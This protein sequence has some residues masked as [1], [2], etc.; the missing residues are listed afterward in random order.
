MVTKRGDGMFDDGAEI[1]ADK[2]E[3][4]SCRKCGRVIDVAS[5]PAFSEVS[6]PDCGTA[7]TVPAKLG[8]FLLLE[9]LGTGGMGAVYKALD[10][11]LGRYVAIKVMKRS[12]GDN[13]QFIENFMREARA[14]A[15]L[16]HPN[17]VQIYSCGQEKGQPYIVMEL[18]SGGRLDE[19]IATGNPM[20]EVRALEIGIDIAEGL[21]AAN[22]V[23]LIHG[24]V[25]PA[26]ILFD[27]K[28]V[29]KVVDFGLARFVGFQ[30][31]SG[32][33]WGT[34]YYIA[35]E[36][37]R[38]QKVDHRSDIYSLGATLYHALGAKPPFDGNTAAD[39]VVARLK[40]PAIGLRVIRPGLQPETADVIA[41]MLEADPFMRYPTYPSLIADLR[42]ALR[43]A[44]QQQ[45]VVHKKVKKTPVWPFAL[46]TAAILAVLAILVVGIYRAQQAP[47]PTAE[48]S[49]TQAEVAAQEGT[50]TTSETAAA[51][52]QTEGE[53]AKPKTLPN[54]QPFSKAGEQE[55]LKA[56]EP[57][58]QGNFLASRN[59]L[60]QLYERA[61]VRGI[62]RYWIRLLQVPL[63][64]MDGQTGDARSFLL[65]VR[66]AL[67]EPLAGGVPHPGVLP[68]TLAAYILKD[69][70]ESSVVM[71]GSKWATPWYNEM[72]SFY[73]GLRA[74]QEGNAA[75]AQKY[76]EEY[77]AHDGD[78]PAWPYRLKSLAQRVLDQISL[79]RKL[80]QQTESLVASQQ[81][82]RARA[83]LEAFR[84]QTTPLL[85]PLVDNRLQ[86]VKLAEQKEAEARKQAERR[87]YEKLIQ[88]DLDRI[89]QMREECLPLLAQKDF[90]RA[91]ANLT[92]IISEL[93]TFEGQQTLALA[94][95]RYDRCDALKRFLIARISASP[96]RGQSDLGGEAVAADLNG[97]RIALGVHGVMVVA[98]EQVS[99]RTMIQMANYYLLDTR[100][101]AKERAD[102]ALSA[103]VYCYENAILKGASAFAA[104][105]I[106]LQPDLKD[107]IRQLMPDILPD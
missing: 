29:A 105:V 14:A 71:E 31:E 4:I 3:R 70:D 17:V 88:T 94:R 82:S 95:E 8:Q 18:V 64:L 85:H 66:G 9:L 90:R 104:K 77:L 40:N 19:I 21:K 103:A 68:K 10:Q 41:R 6:C 56:L 61:P 32:E 75:G 59:A 34:P 96:F 107:K 80:V 92:R 22:D 67:L 60:Q 27:Q 23:G 11:T 37:A 54:A 98:W 76:F 69:I 102:A 73:F 24:D 86:S 36:K 79:F 83:Q 12:L 53:R 20:D 52:S 2:V 33:I 91:S 51:T 93:K 39:V 44:K 78:N 47:Q 58:A 38:G 99:A 13:P 26:N 74:L 5:L 43:V 25:K 1:I 84:S 16:N 101:S 63:A 46:A 57:M 81:A 62:A 48:G 87:Q 30:S 65:E 15:A 89:D 106:E 72:A 49:E 28:G 42:E 100:L 50:T 45:R 35:P 7:Q 55:V 97:V